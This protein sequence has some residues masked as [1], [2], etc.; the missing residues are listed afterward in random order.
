MRRRCPRRDLAHE[1]VEGIAVTVLVA[2]RGP[3]IAALNLLAESLVLI[4]PPIAHSYS[5]VRYSIPRQLD[6]AR[7]ADPYQ[8]FRGGKR[9]GF[10]PEHL[11]CN[12]ILVRSER[13]K[14]PSTWFAIR[15]WRA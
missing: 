14:V 11:V 10:V 7:I 15:N 1:F 4:H 3:Q 13:L 5:L 6:V 2:L 8:Q 12:Q 9:S